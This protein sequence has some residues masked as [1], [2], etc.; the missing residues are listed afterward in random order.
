MGLDVDMRLPFYNAAG[1]LMTASYEGVYEVC[2][3]Q[4]LG[5]F[6]VLR[7]SNLADQCC[8]SRRQPASCTSWMI[9]QQ[10]MQ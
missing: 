3:R 1:C 5:S 6:H 10:I 9:V 7:R 2:S 4:G 8:N